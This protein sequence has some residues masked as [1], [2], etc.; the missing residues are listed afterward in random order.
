MEFNDYRLRKVKLDQRKLNEGANSLIDV[1]KLQAQMNDA[2][3]SAREDSE[4]LRDRICAMESRLEEMHVLIEQLPQQLLARLLPSLD[5]FAMQFPSTPPA[6]S[7]ESQANAFPS[8][9]NP[10]LEETKFHSLQH[11]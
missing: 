1:A 2:I 5:R 4:Q 10:E 3:E 6:R 9:L 11:N 8:P 7:L